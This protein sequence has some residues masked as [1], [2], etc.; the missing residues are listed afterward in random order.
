MP[1]IRSKHSFDGQF[2]QI[3]NAWLRDTRLSLKA[4]GLLAQLM[5]HSVGWK[6]SVRTLAQANGCGLDMIRSAIDELLEHG[7]LVRSEQ[8]ERNAQGHL[9]D[10]VYATNEP[11]S[12]FPTLENPTLENPT[13]KNTS[14]KEEHVKETLAQPTVGREHVEIDFDTFWKQYPRKVGKDA[15]RRLFIRLHPLHRD[16]MLAGVTRFANDP[17]LPHPQFIP[18]ATTWLNRA[19]WDDEPLPERV[20]TPEEKKA[21]EERELA[22][23]RERERIKREQQ[24]ERERIEREREEAERLAN[25][26]ERCEHDRILVLCKV[27]W[28]TPNQRRRTNT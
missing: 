9:G 25:P 1:I 28:D 18:H 15:A 6:I 16:D 4:I 20:L 22:E 2:T 13:P 24:R 3:P 11:T 5:S 19:G 10:Y 14:S 17:N 27:C 7:Y 12:A 8:R 26:V 23:R 21:K